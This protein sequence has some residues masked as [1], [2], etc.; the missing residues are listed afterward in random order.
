MT[1]PAVVLWLYFLGAALSRGPAL[2]YAFSVAGAFQ[3]LQMLPGE[4][5]GGANLLPQSICAVFLIGKFLARPANLVAGLAVAIDVRRLAFLS[6]FLLY[7]VSTAFVLPWLFQDRT[8]VIS[9]GAPMNGLTLL[10]PSAQ[11][12]TQSGYMI[13]SVLTCVVFTVLGTRD[14]FRRHYLTSLL[15]GGV[16]LIVTGLIDMSTYS[17]GLSALLDPFRNV[18]YGLLADVEALAQK[19]V[20]GLMPEASVYGGACVTSASALMF[21]RPLFSPRLRHVIVPIVILCLLVMAVLSTSSGAL[22][23]LV[24]LA[25]L[26]GLNLFIRLGSEIAPDRRNLGWE[27]GLLT[28]GAFL[29]LTAFVLTPTLFTPLLDLVDNAIFEKVGSS[30][31]IE[32]GNWTLVAW[33][34]FEETGY[35]GVGLGGVRSSNWVVS[36]VASTGAVGATLLFAFILIQFLLPTTSA[37]PA[38]REL[39]RGARFSMLPPLVISWLS[40]TTPDIGINAGSF[41][42]LIAATT[43]DA[44][45]SVTR[46]AAE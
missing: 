28:L 23:G 13:I 39:R 15:L 30:S 27:I 14:D 24:I 31:Y 19:R 16:T 41:Y 32:R 33:N 29:V 43:D 10:R 9:E 44:E 17:L 21:L 38:T 26:Y 11:N 3:T 22:I 12:V 37:A 2:L 35:W 45:V 36:V 1:W 34:A 20:V 46:S 5:L 25:G 42:G 8:T 7:A 18:S 6:A 4:A 40:G